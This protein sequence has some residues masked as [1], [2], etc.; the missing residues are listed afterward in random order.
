MIFYYLFLALIDVM[1]IFLM[2]YG[3]LRKNFRLS[4]YEVAK[5]RELVSY[6]VG[7]VAA[8]V[9][10]L[11]AYLFGYQFHRIVAIIVFFGLIKLISK[12]ALHTVMSIYLIDFTLLS[13]F[14]VLMMALFA[15]L[16]IEVEQAVFLVIIQLST[17]FM[18]FVIY[19]SGKLYKILHLVENNLILKLVLLLLTLA[20]FINL[21]ILNFEYGAVVI[22]YYW[23]LA[24][25]F[26]V[27]I[28]QVATMTYRTLRDLKHDYQDLKQAFRGVITSIQLEG[29]D[30]KKE[31][32]EAKQLVGI[33]DLPSLERT[34]LTMHFLTLIEQKIAVVDQEVTIDHTID[35]FEHHQRVPFT[36]INVVLELMIDHAI[37]IWIDKPIKVLANVD[38]DGIDIAV[39][40][41]GD[42]DSKIFKKDIDI[43][44]IKKLV[45]RHEG[46][47]A[48]DH[49]F[50]TAYQAEYVT[51]NVKIKK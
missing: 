37:R 18:V 4:L 14:Q 34:D 26:L 23:L 47:F 16:G 10:G 44:N 8:L 33:T 46:E 21:F 50:D 24:G 25:A 2:A 19:V 49:G 11:T 29:V 12:K 32:E 1:M 36:A 48:V 3:L 9:L 41:Q 42:K 20:A 31:L 22:F 43:Q 45:R 38:Y 28:T 39:S 7:I 27:A 40:Y 17:L 13:V 6:G 15:V 51:I 5:K 30:V 35:Y